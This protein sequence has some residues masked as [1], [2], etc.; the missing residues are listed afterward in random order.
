MTVTWTGCVATAAL[1]GG[2]M[3]HIYFNITDSSQ[4]C[5]SAWRLITILRRLCG[6]VTSAGGSCDS[7]TFPS[8]GI[9]LLVHGLDIQLHDH[10]HYYTGT[11][12]ESFY[13]HGVS[14][15]RGVLGSTFAP[16]ACNC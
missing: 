14:V 12:L 10:I 16:L 6:Q 13:M 8:N 7:A 11:G 1:E 15:T 5:P 3:L 4:Q 9:Q 2:H